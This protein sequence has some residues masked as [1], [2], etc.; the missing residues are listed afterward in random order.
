MKKVF[1][2]VISWTLF[3][4]GD[5]V[6]RCMHTEFTGWLYPAYN[7]LMLWSSDVQDWSAANGPWEEPN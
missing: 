5:A 7:K 1:G 3:W 2:W 4:C 6:S